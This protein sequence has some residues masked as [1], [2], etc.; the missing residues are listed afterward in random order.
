MNRLFCILLS[1]VSI[2][3]NV[4]AD[5]TQQTS[6][7][8]NE[9]KRYLKQHPESDTDED[10][11][12][13][14]WEKEQHI[15]GDALK[16]LVEG[17]VHK[18]V[19]IPMRDG[20]EI[21]AEVFLPSKDG[22]PTP[23]VVTRAGYGRWRAA[24][25]A[26]GANKD[27]MAFVTTDVRRYDDGKHANFRD[28]ESSFTQ[29]DDMY[30]I[31]E[32]LVAQPWCNG[33]IGTIGGSGNGF[34][35]SMG[36]WSL[37]PAYIANRAGNTAGNVKVYW[38]YHNAVATY[39]IRWV[40]STIGNRQGLER[41]TLVKQGYDYDGWIEWITERA[42]DSDNY[43]FNGTGWFDPLF[44]AALDDFMALQHTG[45]AFVDI[46]PRGHGGT[47]GF[48]EKSN[49]RFPI[50]R[51]PAGK[52]EGTFPKFDDLLRGNEP[53]NPQSQIRYFLMGDVR[54]SSAPGNEWVFANTWPPAST[55]TNLYFTEG[56]Q[57]S[58][59]KPSGNAKALYT[60][61]PKNPTPSFGGAYSWNPTLSGP[62]DQSALRER[63][64]VLYFET[65]PLNAP[66]NVTGRITAK[67]YISS[68]A[69]DTQF[70]VKLVDIYPDGYEAVM[71]EAPFMARYANGYD[72][73][74][75]LED[76]QVYELDVD[77]WSTANVFNKGHKIG[78]IV[79]SAAYESYQ[80]HPN[81][82]DQITL[83][84]DW[85]RDIK[86]RGKPDHEDP[87]WIKQSVVAENTLYLS[88]DHPSH[89]TLPVI[90]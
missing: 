40:N 25:Y 75:P 10:G 9:L 1:L 62:H 27:R 20:Y 7:T 30:D 46:D 77:L 61:D 70:V 45:K 32:W 49:F 84:A 41:P 74:A 81:T 5:E 78:V 76:G 87:A 56:G 36:F 13:G 67:L 38:G 71:R 50:H 47:S 39:Q 57:L 82:Y 29:I 21:M 51:G 31:C 28:S 43:Y 66:V 48:G 52:W 3:G 88:A 16:E 23:V 58:T 14:W 6:E 89:I 26:K 35:A 72:H 69:K 55:K 19:R 22:K 79:S 86:N 68:T 73:P 2:V 64:D 42:K 12:L 90:E 54:D 85:Q 18:H 60:Y 53:E 33:R 24:G 59:T 8:S 15:A 37:H 44:Q 65:A 11:V 83:D 34:A 17:T 63:K 80:I 4:H